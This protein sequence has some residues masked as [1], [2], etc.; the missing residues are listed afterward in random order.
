MIL[1]KKSI[2]T[3]YCYNQWEI[4]PFDKSNFKVWTHNFYSNRRGD[5]LKSVLNQGTQQKSMP[6]LQLPSLHKR[7]RREGQYQLTPQEKILSYIHYI[8]SVRTFQPLFGDV[9]KCFC[10]GFFSVCLCESIFI[11]SLARMSYELWVCANYGHVSQLFWFLGLP[12]CWLQFRFFG[13]RVRIS[14]Y[15]ITNV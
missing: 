15:T 7:H 13:L 6:S 1:L 4:R 12:M 8:C 14:F 10:V 11:F 9:Q 3:S 5:K 2:L